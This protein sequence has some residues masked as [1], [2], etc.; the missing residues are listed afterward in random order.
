MHIVELK[1]IFS[2]AVF[3][4]GSLGAP[5]PWALRGDQAGD[6]FIIWGDTLCTWNRG[7]IG[8]RAEFPT[9]GRRTKHMESLTLVG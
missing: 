8:R 6:H 9:P 2:G 1:V 4:T 7:T 5:F 3:I